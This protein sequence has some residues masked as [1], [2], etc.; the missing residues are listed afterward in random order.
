MRATYVNIYLGNLKN[1]ILQIRKNIPEKTKICIPV[2]ADAYGHGAVNISKTAVECGVDYLAVA[3][4]AE[5]IEL[6]NEGI[7]NT[8]ILILSIPQPSEITEVL[9]YNLIPVVQDEEFIFLLESLAQKNKKNVPVHL[10]IDTGM[11]RI[12]CLPEEAIDLAKKIA[13]SKWLKLDGI[14]SHL[15]VPDSTDIQ[16]RNFTANQIKIFKDTVGKIKLSGIEPGICHISSSAA[17][18]YYPEF[19]MDMVR[20][21]LAIYGYYPNNKNDDIS[22]LPVMELCST[23]V[24]IRHMKKGQTVS[25]GRTWE[26]PCDC[27]IGVL[28]IGYGDGLLRVYGKNLQVSINGKKYPVCGRICMDQCMVFLGNNGNSVSRWDKTVIFGPKS[29]GAFQDASDIAAAADTIPYE[30]T[31][32]INKRVPRIY[33]NG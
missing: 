29:F 25:Y 6:R 2:K 28:P 19:S 9:Q 16:D 15:P 14:F 20:P 3:T 12:G 10:K 26:A 1:N 33:I 11:G 30:I 8:P 18:L 23:I 31:C 7:T 13:L 21:G 22:L 5:G 17:V 32:G 27:D 4:V 24:A